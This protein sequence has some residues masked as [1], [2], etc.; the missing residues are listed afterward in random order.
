MYNVGYK[1]KKRLLP[2]RSK[3]VFPLIPS[4]GWVEKIIRIV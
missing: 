1:I 2:M 4:A 3:I